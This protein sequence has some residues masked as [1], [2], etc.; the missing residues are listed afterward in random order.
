MTQKNTKSAASGGKVWSRP[1]KGEGRF[2]NRLPGGAGKILAVGLVVVLAAFGLQYLWP[3]GFPLNG[4]KA[5]EKGAVSQVY[6]S[7][8][9][10]L[11]EIMT[12]N[13]TALILPNGESPDW[14]EITNAGDRDVNLKGYSLAKTNNSLAFTFPNHTLAPGECVLV[15]CD[16]TQKEQEGGDFHAPFRLSSAS[17]TM[18]LFNP[19]G[20]A[21]DTVNIP[22]L[23]R[24]ESYI[25]AGA[26]SWQTTREY[27]PGLANTQESYLS[28]VSVTVAD[29]LE[30]TEVMASN[31]S[32]VPDEN[33]MYWDYVELHNTSDRDVNLAGYYLSDS[34]DN[35]MKWCFPDAVL[36]AG[37]YMIVYASGRDTQEGGRL[38]TNF[39]LSSEGE[40]AVLSNKRGQPVSI[41]NYGLLKADQAYSKMPDGSFSTDLAP[42]PGQ[43]NTQESAALILDQIAAQNTTGAILSEVC[44]SSEIYEYDWVELKNVTGQKID[45]S[46]FGLSDNGASPRKWQFPQGTILPAG[47]WL[48]VWMSGL[49]GVYD[50]ELHAGFSLAAEGRD[51]LSL[52]TP[53]GAIVDRIYLP[54]QYGDATY[55]REGNTSQLRYF[56]QA[57]PGMENSADARYGRANMPQATVSG[58]LYAA[59]ERLLV[60]LSVPEGMR[61]YYTLDCSAPDETSTPYA[62]PISIGENTV[63]RARCY[64]DGLLP[65]WIETQ[66]YFFGVEHAMRVVSLVG[67]P[68]DIFGDAGIYTLYEKTD[69]RVEGHVE[70]FLEDGETLI[71]Q[72]CQLMLHGQDSR[73]LPQKNFNVIA[74]RDYGGLDEFS[75][76]IFTKRDAEAYH[77]FVL[78]SSSEDG[79]K[80]RMRD[81]VLATLAENTSVLY[82]ETELCVVYINGAY[83]GHYNIRERTDAYGICQFE[84]WQ[85]Q[86]DEIDVIKRKYD[87]LRGEGQD[88]QQLVQ[89]VKEAD[90]SNDSA[91]ETLA[92]QMDIRN[93]QEYIALEIFTGNT[94]TL[95]VK[96]YR[97]RNTDGLWRWALYDLDWA[98]YTDTDSIRRWLEKGEDEVSNI[99]DAALFKGCM[100]NAGFREEFLTLLGEKMA[101]DWSSAAVVQKINA[102]YQ[103]LLPELPA[104]GARWGQTEADYLRCLEDLLEYARTRP[105][106]LIGY[107]RAELNLSD[108]DTQ[109][110]FGAALAEIQRYQQEGQG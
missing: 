7:G 103:A 77:S 45:L 51:S 86:E 52:A 108:E 46:G 50:G 3:G 12:S 44:A 14:V 85:G 104:Q 17:D 78:R 94:D 81:S 9:I 2:L 72:G 97:N 36:P 96:R 6:A 38:H 47:G 1:A 68:Q 92:A 28:L 107:T 57:T 95:N 93:F 21:I 54:E 30:I 60:E 53:E 105:E 18:M 23:S 15:Y 65:S 99:V 82:Q 67:D 76:R 43:P 75:G 5:S 70:M 42:T 89:W 26:S 58:G 80:T 61:V 4:K 100:E 27:T 16:G 10:R 73:K 102:R 29:V 69:Y 13:S 20:T 48:C 106:K 24:N 66:T 98:F 83:W 109:R 11:N 91:Y 37:G 88:F 32:Y 55:G 62:G 22:A 19:G 79:E 63:L 25:R 59:G 84:G 90:L 34:A 64:G 33:G 56:A 87:V 101:S 35:A 41:V 31:A 8:A 49:D 71:S 40:Q 39:R 74:S 110:Y